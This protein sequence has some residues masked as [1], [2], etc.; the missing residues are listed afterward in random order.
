LEEEELEADGAM[1]R[2]N[3]GDAFADEDGDDRAS[4]RKIENRNWQVAPVDYH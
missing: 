4:G 3:Q 2:L 1:A